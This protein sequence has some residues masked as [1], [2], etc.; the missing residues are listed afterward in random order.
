[1][2]GKE[3]RGRRGE[4]RGKEE[5]RMDQ[6]TIVQEF[7]MRRL[8]KRGRQRKWDGLVWRIASARG[9]LQRTQRLQV[10]PN[11]ITLQGVAAREQPRFVLLQNQRQ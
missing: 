7:Q 6:E 2:G 3:R 10:Q 1:V 4:E 5:E 9:S 8:Q 11:A